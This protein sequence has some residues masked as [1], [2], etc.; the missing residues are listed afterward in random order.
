MKLKF[1][2][3][4]TIKHSMEVVYIGATWCKTCKVIKPEITELCRKFN[5]SL[6]TLD[7]DEDL[8]ESEQATIRKVPTIRILKDGKLVET[9]DVNQTKS[10][11]MYLSMN[12]GIGTKGDDDF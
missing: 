9:F 1:F 4:H 5:V 12:V 11:E 3:L 6:K 2:Q 8:E 7:L 10:T